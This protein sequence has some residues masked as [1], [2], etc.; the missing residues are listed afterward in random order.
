MA[1]E[2]T[3]ESETREKRDPL[4]VLSA[5][6]REALNERLQEKLEAA[7]KEMK[8][9][10]EAE[11]TKTSEEED[12][13]S[14]EEKKE[15]KEKK[16]R[17]ARKRSESGDRDRRGSDRRGSDRRGS[18][19]PEGSVR[20][21]SPDPRIVQE[22]EPSTSGLYCRYYGVDECKKWVSS[23]WAY[24][25]HMCSKH[26]FSKSFA[27]KFCEAQWKELEHNLGPVPP[28]EKEGAQAQRPKASLRP[29]AEPDLRRPNEPS[30]PPKAHRSSASSE[31]PSASSQQDANAAGME[32]LRQMW[33]DVASRV[34]KE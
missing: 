20:A 29:A 3:S 26:Q 16:R 21:D 13:P 15:K 12:E 17:K 6:Q 4:L 11:P 33:Q 32:L 28:T 7:K 9:G 5:E 2:E 19:R 27:E 22:Q 10:P 23:K 34:F 24:K 25:Q 30:R 31:A 1:N 8:A 14:E 18:D